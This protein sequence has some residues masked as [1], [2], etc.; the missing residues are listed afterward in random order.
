[1]FYINNAIPSPINILL[2]TEHDSTSGYTRAAGV[3]YQ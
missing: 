2:G 3:S 1:M